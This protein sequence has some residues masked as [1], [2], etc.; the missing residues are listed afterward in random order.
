MTSPSKLYE[1]TVNSRTFSWNFRFDFSRIRR[2]R[3][4]ST[5]PRKE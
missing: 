4:D 5:N 2:D 1:R 3:L